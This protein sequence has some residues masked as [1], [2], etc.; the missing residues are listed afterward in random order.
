MN[1]LDLYAPV[2][3]DTTALPTADLADAI[4]TA[5]QQDQAVLAIFARSGSLSPSQVWQQGTAAGRGWLLTSVRR[6]ITN[7]TTAGALVRLDA[8]RGGLYGRPEH[9]WVKAA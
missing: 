4:R 6:S 2:Y 8:K 7:L 1:Q 9:V 3:F 5:E